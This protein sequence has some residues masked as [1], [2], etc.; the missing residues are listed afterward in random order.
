M[1]PLV[2][3]LALLLAPLSAACSSDDTPYLQVQGG[4]FVFNYRIAEATMSVVA[5]AVKPLPEGAT[6]EAS[7]TDPAGGPPIVLVEKATPAA[8]KY[9]FSTPPLSGI[10]AETDYPVIVR[11]VDAAGKEL[12]KVETMFRSQLDQSVLPEKPLVVGPVY[13][14]NPESGS[15]HGG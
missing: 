10:V 8:V 15:K 7:F 4:G 3:V 2:R 5:V 11:V 14:P 6:V 1:P 9:D 12:Q 13:T